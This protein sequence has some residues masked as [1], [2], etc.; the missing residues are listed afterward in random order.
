MGRNVATSTRLRRIVILD[1][2]HGNATVIEVG[3]EVVVVDT[4]DRTSLLEFLTQEK[5]ARIG[6]IYLSHA[7]RDHIGGLAQLLASKEVRVDEV[8]LNTDSMKNSASWDDLLFELNAA[9]NKGEL[10][11]T[12]A[13]TV[14]NGRLFKDGRVNVEVLAP[15]KYMAARGPGAKDRDG[16][17][18][19][20]NSISAVLRV[21]QDKDPILLRA[22]DIDEV[23]FDDLLR[24]QKDISARVLVFPHHG[25]TAGR[26]NV[27]SLA[28]NLRNAVKPRVVVFSI[29]RGRDKHPRPDVVAHVRDNWN[30][31]W[32]ACTQLTRHCA[33]NRPK[34]EPRHLARVFADGR[35]QHRCCA[36]SLL[37]ELD[38][39][40]AM[41]P[42]RVVHQRFIS[43]N[44]PTALCRTPAQEDVKTARQIASAAVL[45]A[46]NSRAT[47]P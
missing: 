33:K 1:V 14:D 31:C 30:D 21:L 12:P 38:G 23:G 20:T 19:D 29:A 36:G 41:L 47:R 24:N 26:G 10:K 11:F 18:I 7:D 25:G 15:S 35:S 28:E 4:G 6:A 16:R 45:P 22:A 2:G 44:A 9:D 40:E 27:L 39:T 32:I 5:I 8:Y 34:E 46:A 37:I 42:A 13:L 43:D 3:T 17:T